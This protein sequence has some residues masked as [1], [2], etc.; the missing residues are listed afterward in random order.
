MFEIRAETHVG[1]HVMGPFSFSPPRTS[2]K[3]GM[4]RHKCQSYKLKKIHIMNY[5]NKIQRGIL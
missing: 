4:C 5:N 2:I 3:S 1:H